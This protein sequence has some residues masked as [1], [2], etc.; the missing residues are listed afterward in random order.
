VD[1]DREFFSVFKST[2]LR[3]PFFS[4]SPTDILTA[5]TTFS[6]L[7]SMSDFPRAGAHLAFS[8]L[9]SRLPPSIRLSSLTM[10]R[11]Q[12]PLPQATIQ[13]VYAVAPF[14]FIQP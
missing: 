11:S 4:P 12:V 3:T 1:M 6:D 5:A 10:Y 13:S 9:N 8:R 7:V 2:Q 14:P